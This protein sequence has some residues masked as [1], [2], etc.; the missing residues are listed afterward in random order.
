MP[1]LPRTHREV[2]LASRPEGLPTL[3]DFELVEAP[4]PVPRPGQVLVRNRYFHVFASLRMLMAGAVEG[5]P[6]PVLNPGDT[7]VGAAVGEVVSAPTDAALQPGDLVSHWLGWRE[8]SAVPVPACTVLGEELPD[9]VAHLGQGWTAYAALTRGVE[10]RPGDTVFVSAGGSAIG[11]MAGQIARLL[12]ADRVIGSTSSAEKARRLVAELGYD[13]AVVRGTTPL[14]EQ[15]AKAAPE[16]VDVFFDNV[17]GEMLAAAVAVARPGARFLLIGALAGQLSPQSPGTTAPVQLDS[18]PL[19]LKRIVMR[20]F[21]ADDVD[22]QQ[23]W[24]QRFGRWLREDRIRFPHVRI[25]GIHEAAQALLD[26][27]D[28]K[29]L[30]TVVVEV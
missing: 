25:G 14:V 5:T 16:G 24:L 11:S 10:I 26:L 6:F 27:I 22:A 23:E 9:P 18:F 2:R 13:A 20:G 8:Y 4:L 15:L 7:L 30:G 12:G 3:D 19:I 17:G 29:Y 1:A 28:G 21:S